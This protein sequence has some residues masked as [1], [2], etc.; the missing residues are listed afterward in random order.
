MV[1][2]KDQRRVAPQVVPIEVVEQ[3]AE[4]GVTGGDERRVVRADLGDLR[5][6][7]VGAL[8]VDRPVEDAAVP[9]RPVLLLEARRRLEWL[10]R[11]E[12]FEHQ[13]P[14]VRGAVD[15]EKLEGGLEAARE[16]QVLLVDHELAVDRVLDAL[17]AAVVSVLRPP[18]RRVEV[19]VLRGELLAQSLDR[20]LHHRLPR[21]V[22]LAAHEVPRAEAV[23]I[24]RAAVLEIVEVIAHEV[25]VDPGLPHRLCKRVVE[26][27]ERA[28]AA[29]HEVQATRVQVAPRRHAWQAA[30]EVT[31]EGHRALGEAIEVRRAHP[32]RAVAAERVAAQ[33][34]EKDEYG[35]HREPLRDWK[36]RSVGRAPGG[37]KARRRSCDAVSFVRSSA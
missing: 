24:R 29:M 6:A 35:F 21:V 37:C 7:R 8:L 13:E 34:V 30:D 28:P 3:L 11:I 18:P 26:R 25:R 12:A 5:G 33:R 14:R 22:L 20:R 23:V 19:V 32:R 2:R 31:V 4:I 10:V 17:P 16:R 15:V 1:G 9:A 36:P 27:L